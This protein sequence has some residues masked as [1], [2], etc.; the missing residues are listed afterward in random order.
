MVSS[1][2]FRGVLRARHPLYVCIHK[3]KI[4]IEEVPAVSANS[5]SPDDDER[6]LSTVNQTTLTLQIFNC[7]FWTMN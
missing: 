4:G 7:T 2:L 3:M 6:L 1:Y 5:G